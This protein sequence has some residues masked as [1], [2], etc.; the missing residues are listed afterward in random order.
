MKLCKEKVGKAKKR[1]RT[2]FVLFKPM[3]CSTV[4]AERQ[5]SAEAQTIVGTHAVRHGALG[6][7]EASAVPVERLRPAEAKIGSGEHANPR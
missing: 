1:I 3:L 5:L 2:L 6:L 7:L 4:E